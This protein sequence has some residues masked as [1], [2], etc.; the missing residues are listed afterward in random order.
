MY[1]CVLCVLFTDVA[2]FAD[3]LSLYNKQHKMAEAIIEKRPI[4]MLLL[5]ATKMK[6][7][8]IPSPLRCLDVSFNTKV[9]GF[10][11]ELNIDSHIQCFNAN[12][13]NVPFK[14]KQ[15]VD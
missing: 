7:L 11:P 10:I 1:L 8:L 5:D 15:L 4:G 13:Q 2:F 12:T 14:C 6:S 3:H 9:I